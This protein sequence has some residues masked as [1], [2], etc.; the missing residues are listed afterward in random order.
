MAFYNVNVSVANLR[1]PNLHTLIVAGSQMQ[2][3]QDWMFGLSNMTNLKRLC[4]TS[5]AADTRTIGRYDMKS[6]LYGQDLMHLSYVEINICALSYFLRA[7]EMLACCLTITT[8][9]N[10][11]L[12]FETVTSLML[13]N[14]TNHSKLSQ[15]VPSKFPF[16]KTL[17]LRKES[18]FGD[19]TR[20]SEHPTLKTIVITENVDRWNRAFPPGSGKTVIFLPQSQ[21]GVDGESSGCP[22][23]FF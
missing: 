19:L 18:I 9:V 1:A 22:W 2:F 17:I 14:D 13:L 11:I 12:P 10:S 6:L 5:I 21:S 16:L 20:L 4:L 23:P 8:P 7:L 15:V 3:I